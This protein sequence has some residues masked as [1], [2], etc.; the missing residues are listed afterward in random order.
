MEILGAAFKPVS[1]ELK[2]KKQLNL[3][4]LK[5]KATAR[6]PM[7]V[8]ARVYHSEANGVLMKTVDDGKGDEEARVPEQGLFITGM[9]VRKTCNV[10]R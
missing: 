10:C 3:H 5:H 7:V 2:K 4:G 8:S 6:W 1:S 9:F